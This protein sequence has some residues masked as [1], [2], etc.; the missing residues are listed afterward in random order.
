MLRIAQTLIAVSCLLS[1]AHAQEISAPQ[2]LRLITVAVPK[3]PITKRPPAIQVQEPYCEFGVGPCG[4]LCIEEE[5]KKT[6]DCPKNALPC[7]LRGGHCSCEEASVCKPAKK[8]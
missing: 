7:F 4:G 8:K 6:W 5:G 3:M 1:N 2:G